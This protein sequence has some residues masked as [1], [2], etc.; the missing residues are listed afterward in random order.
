LRGANLLAEKTTSTGEPRLPAE[1]V[2]STYLKPNGATEMSR[3]IK[4]YEGNQDAMGAMRDAITDRYAREVV[5]NGAIDDVAHAAFMRKYQSPLNVLDRAGFKFSADLADT[6]KSYGAVA[7][8]L[9]AVRDAAQSADKDLVRGIISD[10]FGARTPEQVIG[11]LLQDPRKTNL[12]LSRMDAKQARGLVEYMKD[13][14]VQQFSKDGQISPDAINQFLGN[15]TQLQSYKNAIAKVYG[16]AAADQQVTTLR[17]IADAAQRLDATPVPAGSAYDGKPKFGQDA[18]YKEIGFSF[19]TVWSLFRAIVT[20]RTSPSDAAV[21]LG[22][23]GLQTV[24]SNIKTEIYKEMIR[25]PDSAK[26]LLQVMQS[27]PETGAGRAAIRRFMTQVP[28]VAGHFV[29]ANKYKELSGYAAGN[30][31]REQ[32]AQQLQTTEQ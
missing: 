20:G 13:D 12:L 5:K 26:L 14:I 3:Y 31:G 19:R 28:E 24:Q 8:R 2:F 9:S 27:S 15:R 29:G 7:D 22:G 25:D 16:Q 6:A 21:V 10:Q 1:K 32:S 4:L 23:Q 17:K 18:L 30:L 11:E